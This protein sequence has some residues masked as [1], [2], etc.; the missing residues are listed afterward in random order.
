MT[1]LFEERVDVAIRVGDINDS[2][3]IARSATL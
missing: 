2:T 1:D 3:M